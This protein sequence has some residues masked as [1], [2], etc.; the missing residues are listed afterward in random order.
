MLRL[1]RETFRF[2]TGRV[3]TNEHV[4]SQ[5]SPI[6]RLFEDQ[7][8]AAVTFLRKSGDTIRWWRAEDEDE[9]E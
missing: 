5:E 4:V 3:D 2:D 7:G 1:K 8:L 6:G 9:D